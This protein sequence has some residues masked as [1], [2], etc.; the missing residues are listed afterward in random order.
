MHSRSGHWHLID[1][2]IVRKRDGLDV[3]CSSDK[4]HVWRWL[5]DWSTSH[6]QQTQPPDTSIRRDSAFFQM[7]RPHEVMPS[8]LKNIKQEDPP[9]VKKPTNLFKSIWSHKVVPQEFKDASIIHL[10]KRK[11]NRQSCYNHRDKSPCCQLLVKFLQEF[12]WIIS[13]I[14]W[15]KACFQKVSVAL[16]K[17]VVQST[18]PLQLVNSKKSAKNKMWTCTLLL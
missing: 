13:T 16:D 2:A 15:S 8:L 6:Y 5:L 4:G 10:Y 17:T 18:W 9:I 7:E 11:G 14:I 12:S 3:H 1:Y